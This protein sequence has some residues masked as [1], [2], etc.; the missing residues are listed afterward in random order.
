[1]PHHDHANADWTEMLDLD[2]EVLS[3]HHDE[4]IAW[5]AAQAPARARVLDLGAGTGAFSLALARHRPGAEVTAVDVDE[6]ILAHL[7]G[8]A[9]ALGLDGRV[10]TV[11]A[12]LDQTWPALGPADLAWA[13]NSLHHVADPGPVLAQARAALRPGGVL[14]VSEMTVFP[15]FLPDPAGAALEER[16]HAAMSQRRVED[17]MHMDA[18]WAARLA[19][20]GLTVE[21]ERRFDVVMRPPLPAAA[22]RYARAWMERMR[23]GTDGRLSP[24]DL[25]AL[26]A[27]AAGVADRDDLVITASRTVW[28]GRRPG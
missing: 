13:A 23:H 26:E 5:V 15:R 14:A 8:K 10:A 3:E 17:G 1:M 24:A 7:R 22:G 21:A 12:D 19:G 6:D 20:A 27:V 11:L 9:R 28:L 4:V 18:D 25:A 16:A 2:A